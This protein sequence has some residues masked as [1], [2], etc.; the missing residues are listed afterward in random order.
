MMP[1]TGARCR[2]IPDLKT[3]GPDTADFAGGR[4]M[5][6]SMSMAGASPIS[7]AKA[8]WTRYGTPETDNQPIGSGRIQ[9]FHGPAPTRSNAGLT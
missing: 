4:I 9:V 2:R 8:A 3:A 6:Y 7:S 1:V 5:R